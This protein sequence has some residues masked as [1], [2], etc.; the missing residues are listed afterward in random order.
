[1]LWNAAVKTSLAKNFLRCPPPSK[2]RVELARAG[3]PVVYITSQFH[4]SFA[5]NSS[6]RGFPWSPRNDL[7]LQDP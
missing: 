5:L 6:E 2:S 1:M 7:V 3:S 4:E